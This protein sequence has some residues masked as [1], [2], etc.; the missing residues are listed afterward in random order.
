VHAWPTHGGCD[1][2]ADHEK[3]VVVIPVNFQIN[4]AEDIGEK[5]WSN[6]K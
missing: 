3:M 5:D 1:P 4:K 2:S 6:G